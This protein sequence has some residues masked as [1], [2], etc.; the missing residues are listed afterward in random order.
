MHRI[1]GLV[2][3]LFVVAAPLVG[4]SSDDSM[5]VEFTIAHP[6][7]AYSQ[8]VPPPFSASGAAVDESVVCESGTRQIDRHESAE[9]EISTPEE[10]EEWEEWESLREAARADKGG[11]VLYSVEEWVCDDGSGTFTTKL[12]NQADFA[13]P[14]SEQDLPTWEIESGTGDY[15]NLSGSGERSTTGRGTE[16]FVEVYTGQVQTG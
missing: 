12:H 15:A 7:Y 1:A 2:V 4:C 13:K 11:I 5:A 16:D 6:N 8:P 10:W 9:G 3:A 14:E